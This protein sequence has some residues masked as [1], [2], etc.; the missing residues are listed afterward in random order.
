MCRRVCRPCRIGNEVAGETLEKSGHPVVRVRLERGRSKEAIVNAYSALFIFPS[1]LKDEAV[2]KLVERIQQEVVK[3]NGAVESS[4]VLGKRTFARP[5]KK[6]DV[7]QYVRMVFSMDPLRVDALMKRFRIMEDIFRV[8]IIRN[9]EGA[10][11]APA[12]GA[13]AAE[14]QAGEVA[15]AAALA[16]EPA[17]GAGVAAGPV[18]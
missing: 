1:S 2:E 14:P 10:A 17:E 16:P 11:P 9:E 15:Q 6:R 4:R 5:M 7:G 18:S 13:A 12:K 8:Q 3:L